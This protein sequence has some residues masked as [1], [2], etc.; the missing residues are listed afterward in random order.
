[1]TITIAV[2]N[3]ILAMAVLVLMMALAR[4]IN[5]RKMAARASEIVLRTLYRNRE[6]KF[7]VVTVPGY[8][9]LALF[10]HRKKI[11]AAVCM[12]DNHDRTSC[13]LGGAFLKCTRGNSVT[14]EEMEII[15]EMITVSPTYTYKVPIHIVTGNYKSH[16][17]LGKAMQENAKVAVLDLLQQK[18]EI[19]QAQGFKTG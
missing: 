13:A 7:T 18:P 3:L 8:G 1:M 14:A 19:A 12:S 15:A 16:L 9:T 5:W 10:G 17:E 4:R 11:Y 2:Q 6:L